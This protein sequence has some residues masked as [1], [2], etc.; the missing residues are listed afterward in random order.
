[1]LN[2]MMRVELRA[3]PN[4]DFPDQTWKPFRYTAHASTWE[5]AKDDAMHFRDKH[6]LGGG[7][8]DCKVYRRS[9]L[10]GSI[11]YNGRVWDANGNEIGEGRA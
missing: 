3:V 1:M 7:N 2:T 10:L 8:F 9:K 5:Q 11:S 4:P 6:G